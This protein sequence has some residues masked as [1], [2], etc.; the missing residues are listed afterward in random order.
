MLI[1]LFIFSLSI[2]L[3]IAPIIIPLLKRGFIRINY[4]RKEIPSGLGL[5]FLTAYLFTVPLFFIFE[6]TD[7][8][9]I[10]LKLFL[11]FGIALAGLIDDFMGDLNRGFK[12]HFVKLIKGKELTSGMFKLIIGG[13][14]GIILGLLIEDNIF[15]VL[16]NAFLFALAINTFNLMDVRPGRSLKLY[17]FLALLFF[18]WAENWL[19]FLLTPLLGIAF[20][21]LFFDLKEEGMLGDIGSN[22]LGAS[23]GFSLVFILDN[24]AK[25]LVLALLIV[26]QWV[27]DKISFTKIIEDNHL[28][29]IID[30]LGRK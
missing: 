13:M 9:F 8:L 2:S 15:L 11:L 4:N 18:F 23:I 14:L 29:R 30:G 3:I 1:I 6:I 10:L 20:V 25:L 28:L 21:L 26:I 5:I 24:L 16:L 19:I 22:L 17:I 12:G 27:G 7:P